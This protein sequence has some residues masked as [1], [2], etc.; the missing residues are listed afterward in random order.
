[1][2]SAVK[3]TTK[4]TAELPTISSGL[5]TAELHGIQAALGEGI[6][7]D[8]NIPAIQRRQMENLTL[9]RGTTVRAIRRLDPTAANVSRGIHGV[10]FEEANAY[11]DGCGPMVAWD[12]GGYCNVYPGD[13]E[14][15]HERRAHR[16]TSGLRLYLTLDDKTKLISLWDSPQDSA[17]Y[18]PERYVELELTP[19]QVNQLQID[20]TWNV[21]SYHNT[22]IQ[23][24]S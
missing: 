19:A 5:P 20:S 11:G 23:L 16:Q 3:L 8:G 7:I 4:H 2:A 13:V 21:K 9:A 10:V 17:N 24:V 22:S 14:V 18:A 6:A 1:M 12:N 15:I